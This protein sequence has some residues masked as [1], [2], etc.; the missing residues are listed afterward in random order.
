MTTLKL[1]GTYSAL[2]T[3]FQTDGAVDLGALDALV[4]WQLAQGIEGFIPCGTTGEASTLSDAERDAVVGCVVKRCAG[5][6]PVI[7]GTGTND[8]R[9]TIVNQ[10]RAHDAGATHTLVVT[11][12]YNKPTPEGLVRHYHAVAEASSLGIVLYNVPGRT[13]C[14][15]K[16]DTVAKIA[17]HPRILGIKEATGDLDRVTLLRRETRTDFVLLSGDDLTTLPFVLLGGDGVISVVSNVAPRDM[18]DMVRAALAG[19]VTRSRALHDKLRDLHVGLFFESNP[20]PTKAAL[21]LQG[22]MRDACRLPLCEMGAE[23]RARLTKILEA[24][25]WR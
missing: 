9:S 23:P 16:P 2:P 20:I 22:R 10:K 4:E 14:D 8:T 7:A 1:R 13:G 24:G 12:F 21:A 19:D 18:S 15:L 25:G 11:P 5:R 3:P 6:V 17:K